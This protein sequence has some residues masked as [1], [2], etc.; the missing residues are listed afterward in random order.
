MM[1]DNQIKTDKIEVFHNDDK[2]PSHFAEGL[3]GK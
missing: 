2:E 1:L 3:K